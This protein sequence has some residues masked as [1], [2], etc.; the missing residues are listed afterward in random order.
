MVRF[1]SQY[2][3]LVQRVHLS[4]EYQKAT[5]KEREGIDLYL[6]SKEVRSRFSGYIPQFTLYE[7]LYLAFANSNALKQRTTQEQSSVL[8]F[9]GSDKFRKTIDTIETNLI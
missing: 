2:K 1:V 9:L 5:P 7:S 4:E 8:D 6:E 3:D